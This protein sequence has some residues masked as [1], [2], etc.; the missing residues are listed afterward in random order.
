MFGYAKS[1]EKMA[2]PRTSNFAKNQVKNCINF[3]VSKLL[4]L[5]EH[6]LVLVPLDI[7]DVVHED[8]K[9]PLTLGTSGILRKK[10]ENSDY[11]S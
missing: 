4:H 10:L 1:S 5:T 6:A 3:Y 8:V 7:T 11:I 2:P 9:H